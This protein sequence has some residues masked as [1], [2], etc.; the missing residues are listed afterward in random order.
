MDGQY[1]ETYVKRGVLK[2]HK[3]IKALIWLAALVAFAYRPLRV[4]PV[5][6]DRVDRSLYLPLVQRGLRVRLC[7]W[8]D[9]F[10]QDHGR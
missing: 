1:C 2:K 5:R 6:R 4:Y 9:R 8:T 10:R 7:G 3:V